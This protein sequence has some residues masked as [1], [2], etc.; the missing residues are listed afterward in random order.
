MSQRSEKVSYKK[1]AGVSEKAKKTKKAD[2]AESSKKID[3]VDSLSD[4]N[5]VPECPSCQVLA[6][7]VRTMYKKQGELEKEVENLKEKFEE[8]SAV[9][10]AAVQAVDSSEVDEM[11]Q[12][13]RDLEKKM[14]E[15]TNRQLR[16]TLVFRKIQESSEEKT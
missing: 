5:L 11:A 9:Q 16:Q 10:V 4:E 15:R 13:I 7:L 12:R 6:N 3:P 2:S 14:E 1:L 8:G